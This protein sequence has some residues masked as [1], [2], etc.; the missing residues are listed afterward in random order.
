[1]WRVVER[2]RRA[3]VVRRVAKLRWRCSGS[4]QSNKMHEKAQGY[5]SIA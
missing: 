1:M 3:Q 4:G 2:C 5:L